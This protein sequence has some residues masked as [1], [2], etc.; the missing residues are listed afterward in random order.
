VL[1]TTAIRT[2]PL[3]SGEPIPVLGQGT[4]RLV[5][6]LSPMQDEI[7]ALQLGLELGLT[8][9]D[10]AEAYGDG[11]AEKLVGEAIA[12]RRDEVFLVSKV[13]PANATRHGT[14]EACERSLKRLRTDRLDLYLLNWRGRLQVEPVVE[15]F[16]ELVDT[17]KIRH[18]GVSNFDVIELGEL[19]TFAGDAVETDQVVYSLAH[20][21]IEFDLLPWCRERHLPVMAYAP[22]DRGRLLDDVAVRA[23]AL[24]RDATPAQVAI[25]WVLRQDG[26]SAVVRAGT[27]AHVRE[28]RAA[29]DLELTKDDLATLDQ[30]FP[31]PTSPEPLE[32]L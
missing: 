31:P 15:A 5:E 22:T 1:E 20:R 32:I 12:G 29:L 16:T 8:L 3:P 17:G 6:G 4:W 13:L 10:T 7:A 11:S 23:V 2:I 30:E 9:I 19:M 25:A 24:R 14:I 26:V 28:N 18:W 21:G 27:P